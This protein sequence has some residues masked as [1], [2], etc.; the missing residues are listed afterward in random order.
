MSKIA[1][2]IAFKNFCDEEYFIPREI[3]LKKGFEVKTISSEKGI[4]VGGSGGEAKIDISFEDF[5]IIGFDAIV[6][7]GGPGAYKYIEDQFVWEIVRNTIKQG[8]LLAAICIAPVI[9]ARAG[10]LEGKQAT[11]WSSV[12]D[13]KPIHV[14][15]ENGAEYLDKSVVQ[16]GKIITANGPPAAKAFAETII[17]AL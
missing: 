17:Q 13:K 6:F 5:D 4:A 7:V 3:F 9:L 14:L 10:A 1:I 8:K 15:E 2:I 16:D 12:M 11:V